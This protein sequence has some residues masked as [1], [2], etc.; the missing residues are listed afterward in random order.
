MGGF[1][2]CQVGDFAMG[3]ELLR[4]FDRYLKNIDNGWDR[5]PPVYY[6]TV[7]APA[8]HEWSSASRWPLPELPH[9]E[10]AVE[11]EKNLGGAGLRSVRR[12]GA[13]AR[14]RPSRHGRRR[15]RIPRP[16]HRR[17]HLAGA[18][19]QLLGVG[20]SRRRSALDDLSAARL[21]P[22]MHE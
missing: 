9:R 18:A 14:R 12:V 10:A 11:A 4:F 3:V 6:Y 8:G 2:H 16:D 1:S 17:G 21:R 5:E 13:V 7:N 22:T 15:G 20:N 19:G